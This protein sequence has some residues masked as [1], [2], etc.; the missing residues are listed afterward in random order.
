GSYGLGYTQVE[1]EMYG[2]GK[3]GFLFGVTYD[4]TSYF[5]VAATYRS[6]VTTTMKGETSLY[7]E[8]NI[9]TQPAM[10]ALGGLTVGEYADLIN[11]IPIVGPLLGAHSGDSLER[12]ARNIAEDI[13]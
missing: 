9:V 3:P 7:L 2:Y 6:K 4:V 12:F 5:S 8:S 10:E 11:S 13:E 1:S